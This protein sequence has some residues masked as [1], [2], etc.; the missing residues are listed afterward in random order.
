MGSE[1]F[2]WGGMWI[3]PIMFVIMGLCVVFFMFMMFGRGGFRP[4]W[5]DSSRY[6][7]ESRESGTAL[8][9][10]KNRYAKGEITKEEFDQ[11]K[12]DLG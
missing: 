1:F 10:L 3:F 6:S 8:E 12:I 9:I 2:G 4:P 7:S 11:M 5:Q